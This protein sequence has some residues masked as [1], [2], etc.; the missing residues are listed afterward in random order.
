MSQK[1]LALGAALA[2]ALGL[3]ACADTSSSTADPADAGSSAAAGGFEFGDMTLVVG[4]GPGSS[5][6]AG[7]RLMAAQLEERLGTTVTVQN[8][9]GAGGQVGLTA[10]AGAE[11]DG[12]TF[13]TINFPSAIVSVLDETRGA[14][15][16]RESFSPVALMV[17]DPTAVAVLPDDEIQ[18]PEDLVEVAEA[19]PGQLQYTT[20]GVASQEH[21]AAIALEQATGTTL[22]AV[23]FPDGGSQVKTTFLGGDVRLFIA[24]VSDMTDLVEND[25]ARVVGVMEEERSPLLP[26]VPTFTESGYEVNMSS[27]RGFAYP[28]CA[29]E[30]A[31]TALSDAI[32]DV[33]EDPAFLDQMEAAGLAPAYLDSTDYAEYW[34]DREADF[35]EIFDLAFEEQAP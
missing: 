2:V 19:D 21:F 25:Q 11:C 16:T 33:M 9:E 28:S 15:Y 34:S 31:V 26:D 14:T 24:N 12:N 22:S 27:S 35:T 5:T 4:Y 13:G 3:A 23:H 6:D 8:Q 18:T 20:T 17:V 1:S 10:L 7:A 30:A 32:G 29:P